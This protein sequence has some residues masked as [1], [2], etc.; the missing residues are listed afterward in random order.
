MKQFQVDWDK[1]QV[2]LLWILGS[3]LA[4]ALIGAQPYLALALVLASGAA[5]GV[6]AVIAYERR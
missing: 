3:L 5:L 6:A 4:I 2:V 1:L